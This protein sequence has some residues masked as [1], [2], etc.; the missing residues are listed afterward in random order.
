MK[1]IFGTTNDRKVEDLR[2]VIKKLGLDMEVLSMNDIGWDRGEIEETGE[3][4]EINSFIKASEIFKFTEEHNINYPIITDDAGLFCEALPGEPGVYTAR[5]ADDEL[6]KDSSLPKYQCVVKLLRKLNGNPNRN[7]YYKCAVT[8][9]LPNGS[10][11][12]ETGKSDG[13]IADEIIGELKK[14]YFYS[15]FILNGINKVFSELT[16]E[17]LTDTYRYEA[18]KKVLK[19][20]KEVI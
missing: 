10:Y 3:T 7:A 16:E 18:L 20:V 17:E 19:K 11:F 14:P 2:N 1:V 8:C 9:M 6:K 15:V 4:V 13:V 12:V 5:Y